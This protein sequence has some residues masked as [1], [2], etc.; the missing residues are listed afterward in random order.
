MRKTVCVCDRCSIAFSNHE[1]H[2]DV[3]VYR[4]SRDKSGNVYS[5]RIIDLCPECYN[6]LMRFLCRE[7]DSQ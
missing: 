4:K 1:Y 7:G 6:S 2:Q 5:S 3:S